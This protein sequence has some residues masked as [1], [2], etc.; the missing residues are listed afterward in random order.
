MMKSV[1][2]SRLP[3]KPSVAFVISLTLKRLINFLL[4]EADNDR[5]IHDNYRS[6][7]IAQLPEIGQRFRILGDVSL[8][9]LS[10]F[11][12]K[13]LLRLIAEHSPMLRI[14]DDALRHW[15]LPA[16]EFVLVFVRT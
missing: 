3:Y 4:I 6:R 16:D 12:R 13:I 8:Y 9:E 7:H 1:C 2:Q 14:N 5:A 10:A 11:S 15:A